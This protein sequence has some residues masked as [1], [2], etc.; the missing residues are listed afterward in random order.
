MTTREAT[1]LLPRSSDTAMVDDCARSLSDRAAVVAFGA[2][3]WPSVET[4]QL[5]P[6]RPGR[7]TITV[8]PLADALP[9]VA[10]N[11]SFPGAISAPIISESPSPNIRT[12]LPATNLGA[13]PPRAGTR[14]DPKR[15]SRVVPVKSNDRPLPLQASS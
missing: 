7:S 15:P 9:S 13:E 2:I 6:S 12:V 10:R 8:S 1:S 5:K 11:T 14:N 3:Q 4:P